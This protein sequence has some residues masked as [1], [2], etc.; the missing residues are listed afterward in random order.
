[1]KE[2]FKAGDVIELYD[3]R[4]KNHLKFIIVM[5][6]HN[7]IKAKWIELNCHSDSCKQRGW[8]IMN[9]DSMGCDKYE[10]FARWN[11]QVVNGEKSKTLT[12]G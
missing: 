2:Y 11:N 9:E 7:H 12:R 5:I 1:M 4:H 6:F 8:Q 3:N 10:I